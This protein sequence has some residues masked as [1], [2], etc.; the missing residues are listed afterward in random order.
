MMVP[1]FECPRFRTAYGLASTYLSMFG[2]CEMLRKQYDTSQDAWKAFLIFQM[3]LD[4]GIWDI[5]I[6]CG[7][8]QN[9]CPCEPA[10]LVAALRLS[11]A[12][13]GFQSPVNFEML[14][15]S[16]LKQSWFY[17]SIRI[18]FLRQRAMLAD[19]Q[20]KTLNQDCLGRECRTHFWKHVGF[21]GNVAH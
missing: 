18:C 20:G 21:A 5:C 3:D 8:R 14:C 2:W 17:K 15:C 1:E 19:M 4:V 16:Y 7:V 9:L 12:E 11:G 10:F 6:K 13:F